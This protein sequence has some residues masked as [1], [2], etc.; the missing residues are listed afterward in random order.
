VREIVPGGEGGGIRYSY[1]GNDI[2][3]TAAAA[4]AAECT[5]ALCKSAI[6]MVARCKEYWY[7][8]T[9]YINLLYP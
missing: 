6:L 4:A 1:S 2:C 5:N 7:A 8:I 9:V 3:A